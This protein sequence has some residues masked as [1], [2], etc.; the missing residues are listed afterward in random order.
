MIEKMKESCL[1]V[2]IDGICVATGSFV[3]DLHDMAQYRNEDAQK[4]TR[5][6]G[7]YHMSVCAQDEDIVTMAASAA[8]PLIKNST[9]GIRTLLFATESSIDQSKAAG[10]WVHKLLNLGQDCRVVELKQACYSATAALRLACSH[11]QAFP[12]EKVL[13]IASD[14]ARYELDSVAEPTEGCGAVAILISANPRIIKVGSV[15]GIYSEDVMDFWRP[16]YRTC[17]IVD[18]KY[19][20]KIYLKSLKLA[21]GDYLQRG[22][23]ELD[24]FKGFCFHTPFAKM[25]LKAY[26][27]LKGSLD[28]LDEKILEPALKYSRT[29]GNCYTAALY[30][31]LASLLDSGSLAA[32]DK[33]AMFSYGSGCVSEFFHL[34]LVP[35]FEKWLCSRLHQERL[36]QRKQLSYE[37]YRQW[38]QWQVPQDGHLHYFA[39]NIESGYRLR[40]VEDHKRLYE[41]V[42]NS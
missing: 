34:E 28:S 16:N 39:K 6:L 8:Y 38:H 32:H 10:L 7:Q 12:E 1:P 27:T 35:G 17:A 31:G 14:I 15:S 13:V 2:G 26:Q 22:G 29:L 19:S 21:F 5:G 37:Q 41:H 4:Y 24:R 23:L 40:G 18:G 30:I 20:T 42:M 25:A 3:L 33:V 36:V 11:V 9:E